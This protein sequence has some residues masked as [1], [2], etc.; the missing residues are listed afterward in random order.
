MKRHIFTLIILVSLAILIGVTVFGS[1]S[2]I[3]HEGFESLETKEQRDS[4][5]NTIESDIEGGVNDITNTVA[6][7]SSETSTSGVNGTIQGL[8]VSGTP[9]LQKLQREIHDEQRHTEELRKVLQATVETV[10]K[11]KKQYPTDPK[12]AV[13]KKQSRHIEEIREVLSNTIRE[14]RADDILPAR[15]THC[16]CATRPMVN[17]MTGMAEEADGCRPPG[18][19][20]MMEL[21]NRRSK[22]CDDCPL[23]PVSSS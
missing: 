5:L 16:G 14:L 8:P 19:M 3:A 12:T 22:H 11:L 23:K 20:R 9:S 21:E 10:D 17:P 6:G 18:W 1:T 4:I 2:P 15:G 13:D 7:T